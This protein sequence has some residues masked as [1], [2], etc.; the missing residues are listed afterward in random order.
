[1]ATQ[2]DIPPSWNQD[3]L[4]SIWHAGPRS[5]FAADPIAMLVVRDMCMIADGTGRAPLA[6]LA[7]RFRN[8]FRKRREEHKNAGVD[9]PPELIDSVE[10]WAEAIRNNRVFSDRLMLLIGDDLAW[11]PELWSHWSQGFK[12]ALRNMAELKL[13][14]Y[15]ETHVPGGY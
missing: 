4:E 7:T 14:E 10:H 3:L 15:F 6:T 2:R 13:I 12:K 5:E 9:F 11:K 8:F 1:M